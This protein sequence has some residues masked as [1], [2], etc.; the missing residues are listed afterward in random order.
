MFG[1]QDGKITSSAVLAALTFGAAQAAAAVPHWLTQQGRLTNADGSPVNGRVRFVF[2]IVDENE[3]LVWSEQ[4]PSITVE[5]GYFSARL[6]ES[7]RLSPELFTSGSEYFLRVTVNG[8]EMTPA[9]PLGSVPFAFLAEN[10]E[11]VVGGSVDASS[12]SVRGQPVIDEDGQWVGPAL[13]SPAHA[14]VGRGDPEREVTAQCNVGDPSLAEWEMY[15]T[16]LTLRPVGNQNLSVVVHGTFWP[17]SSTAC[18]IPCYQIGNHEP[19]PAD[20]SWAHWGS[21]SGY[22]PFYVDGEL[23][24]V[25]QGNSEI[26]VGL[27]AAMSSPPG[28]LGESTVFALATVDD[29]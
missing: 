23:T 16:A 15:A 28:Y 13:P 25:P 6:G 11:N 17:Q 24:V 10:A 2:E 14:G 22:S 1:K 9:Q 3:A 4:Q 12:I 7:G 26:Q 27:C 20:L 18:I 21:S 19:T 29:E 5:D 8:E